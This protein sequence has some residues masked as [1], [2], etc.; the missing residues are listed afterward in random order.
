MHI[1]TQRPWRVVKERGKTW[2]PLVHNS[3]R[4]VHRSSASCVDTTTDLL[5]LRK[6]VGQH[7]FG[8]VP[9][10]SWKL[11][12][13]INSGKVIIM[14]VNASWW[15]LPAA[16]ESMVIMCISHNKSAIRMTSG[17]PLLESLSF[18]M[19]LSVWL[20]PRDGVLLQLS[21]TPV[22]QRR[23]S[24]SIHLLWH[25]GGLPGFRGCPSV[26]PLG[27]LER[28]WRDWYNRRLERYKDSWRSPMVG[29][30]RVERNNDATKLNNCDH[31]DGDTLT[32]A[33]IFSSY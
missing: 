20:R 31:A 4:N 27:K 32:A 9:G 17:N 21:S 28:R 16:L 19:N 3:N 10:K 22:N 30:C 7:W 5:P 25:S 29:I 23:R 13:A 26:P 1:Y 11:G 15:N 6:R 8:E 12:Q 33:W 2:W 24:W 18:L 14:V